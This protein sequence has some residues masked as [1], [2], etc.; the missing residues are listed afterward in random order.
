L[1]PARFREEYAGVMERQFRDEAG[2]AQRF[3][4]AL[5]L[6]TRMLVDLS[7]SI[8]AQIAREVCY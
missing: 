2:E 6:W 3:W 7:I 4:A 5:F 8:P 1:Y